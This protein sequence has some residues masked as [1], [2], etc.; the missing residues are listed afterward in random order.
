MKG[1]VWVLRERQTAPRQRNG[2]EIVDLWEPGGAVV[3]KC[4][5]LRNIAIRAAPNPVQDLGEWLKLGEYW[6]VT[7][8]A[9]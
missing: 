8:R 6:I 5:N 7:I 4:F 9:A 1:K 2:W 3:L